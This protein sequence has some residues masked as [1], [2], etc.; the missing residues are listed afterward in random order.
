[1]AE[2]THRCSGP[3]LHKEFAGKEVNSDVILKLVEDRTP[4]LGKHMRS[5]LKEREDTRLPA[6]ERIVVLDTKVDGKP[7]RKASFPPGVLVTFPVGNQS[8][9]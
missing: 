7:R 4:F 2:T 6:D 9:D 5:V 3:I 1:L 8:A